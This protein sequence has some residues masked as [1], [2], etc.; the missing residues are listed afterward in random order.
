MACAPG[1][2]QPDEEQV[3]CLRGPRQGGACGGLGAVDK[4]SGACTCFPGFHGENCTV[5]C[6]AEQTCEG[7][8]VCSHGLMAA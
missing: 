2:Y 8:G 3:A 1:Q 7:R 4:V 5:F 6:D